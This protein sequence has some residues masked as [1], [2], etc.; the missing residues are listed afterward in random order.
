MHIVQVS[1]CYVNLKQESGGVANV[2]RQ[3]CLK[4][5]EKGHSITLIC[6]NTELGKVVSKPTFFVSEEGIHVHVVGQYSNTLLGPYHHVDSSL[7]MIDF[8]SNQSVIA[9]VHTCFSAITE[10][11]MSF[12]TSQKIPFVF[13]PHGKLSPNMLKNRAFLKRFWWRL[14]ASKRV[15]KAEVIGVLAESETEMFSRLGLSNRYAVVPNGFSKVDIKDQEDINLPQKY[16]LYLGYIDPRK[17]PDFLVKAFAK[18]KTSES[19]KL[20]IVGPD[21]YGYSDEVRKVSKSYGIAEKVIFFG[22]AYG[23]LKWKILGC[24]S[25]LCLPSLGEGQPIVL[26]E[27]LGSGLPTVY[28][29]NCNFPEISQGNAGVE[30]SIFSDQEWANAIDYIVL[31]SETQKQMS[32]SALR[33]SELYTWEAAIAK[34]ENLYLTIRR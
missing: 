8:I 20:L 2:V 18:S 6:S 32:E 12:F 17:Q 30:L 5:R 1:P 3:L 29:T 33:L 23:A 22:P 25:C 13:S 27:S 31:N 21:G 14:I 9:H 26:C 4:L 24:A 11:A 10:C 28:S 34:W 16:V 7:K 19:H 15:S